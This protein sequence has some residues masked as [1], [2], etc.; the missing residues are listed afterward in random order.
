MS[1]P[2]RMASMSAEPRTGVQQAPH[3]AAELDRLSLALFALSVLTKASAVAALPMAAV[4][5]WSQR[6]ARKAS[7]P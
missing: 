7:T 5:S 3:D 1:Q 2:G 6:E 4:L